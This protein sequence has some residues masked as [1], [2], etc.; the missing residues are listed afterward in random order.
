MAPPY[1]ADMDCHCR[2][3]G[4]GTGSLQTDGSDRYTHRRDQHAKGGHEADPAILTEGFK[5]DAI[6]CSTQINGPVGRSVATLFDKA[7]TFITVVSI[8]GGTIYFIFAVG[9]ARPILTRSWRRDAWIG[10]LTAIGGLY[11]MALTQL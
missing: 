1:L 11:L 2:L 6:C 10:Y 8:M 4:S 5:R 9:L 7:L 3:E